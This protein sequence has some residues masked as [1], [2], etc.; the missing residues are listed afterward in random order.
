VRIVRILGAL[1]SVQI[2]CNTTSLYYRVPVR[3]IC[4]MQQVLLARNLLVCEL[5]SY[6]P[7][8][9]GAAGPV[10]ASEPAS[11]AL[12][13]IRP[14]AIP[15]AFYLMIIVGSSKKRQKPELRGVRRSR[16]KSKYICLSYLISLY[17]TH[18]VS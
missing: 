2:L 14:W 7:L 16:P 15:L 1:C 11:I 18:S 10:Y 9:R 17:P 5:I 12:I 4:H 8:L 3:I 6:S 13:K